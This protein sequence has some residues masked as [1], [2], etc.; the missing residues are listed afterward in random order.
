MKKK[1]FQV[2]SSLELK[3]QKLSEQELSFVT[4]GLAA[5]TD[6]AAGSSGSG[7]G[8]TCDNTRVHCCFRD[9]VIQCH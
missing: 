1:L 4:G 9:I 3:M 7:S 2:K 5:A 8:S 6:A